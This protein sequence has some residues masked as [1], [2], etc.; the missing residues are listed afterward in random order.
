MAVTRCVGTRKK[1]RVIALECRLRLQ[2]QAPK[3]GAFRRSLH[4]RCLRIKMRRAWKRPI[5]QLERRKPAGGTNSIPSVAPSTG[6]FAENSPQ[7]CCMDAARCRRA[8]DGPSGNPRRK[9]GTEEASGIRVAFSLDTFFWRRKRKY[10]AFG[11]ENP[12]QSTVALATPY[13]AR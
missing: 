11:C 5:V 12:I 7:G 6:A 13:F 2:A 1:L 4:S 10:L 9:R 8:K 3:V